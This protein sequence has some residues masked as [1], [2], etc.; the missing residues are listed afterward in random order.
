MD[1]SMMSHSLSFTNSVIKMIYKFTEGK[2]F[3]IFMDC[4]W[5]AQCAT[6]YP[7]IISIF[8]KNNSLHGTG[9]RRQGLSL[10]DNLPELS[11]WNGERAEVRQNWCECQYLVSWLKCC[12]LSEDLCNHPNMHCIPSAEW[13]LKD[14]RQITESQNF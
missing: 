11:V 5:K 3:R 13:V 10:A 12:W 9:T 4:L 8:R 1:R 2:A 14:R 6:K 7:C